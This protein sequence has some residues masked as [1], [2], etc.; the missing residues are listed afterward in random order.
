MTLCWCALAEPA[1]QP[2][3]GRRVT[4]IREEGYEHE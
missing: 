3:L 4:R 2:E 1:E